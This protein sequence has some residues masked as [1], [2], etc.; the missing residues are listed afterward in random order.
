[1][2]LKLNEQE[3]KEGQRFLMEYIEKYFNHFPYDKSEIGNPILIDSIYERLKTFF[4]IECYGIDFDHCSVKTY[5]AEDEYIRIFDDLPCD[6]PF[7]M[8][9]IVFNTIE[10]KDLAF[11][12]HIIQKLEEF[13]NS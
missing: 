5:I 7:I 13:L 11:E 8:A 2:E 6:T 12:Y 4:D 9:S 10:R 1:M 3:Y